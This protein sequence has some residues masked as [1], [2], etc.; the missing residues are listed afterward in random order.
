MLSII[1]HGKAPG[2]LC[3][4]VGRA[5][6]SNPLALPQRATDGHFPILTDPPSVFISVA[7][8]VSTWFG[9]AGQA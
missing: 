3:G 1:S 7:C 2:G 5:D 9:G 4:L 8:K 6:L